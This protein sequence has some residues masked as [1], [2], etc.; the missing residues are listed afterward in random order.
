ME[1]NIT[2]VLFSLS[3]AMDS[4]ENSLLGVHTNHGKRVACLASAIGREAYGLKEQ[5][6]LE[7]SA[8]CVMHDNALTEYIAS[9]LNYVP[10]LTDAAKENFGRHCEIGERN[11]RLMPF[12]DSLD[13]VVLYHHEN[14]DGS[15]PF[16]L[17]EAQIPLYAQLVHFADIV[18]ATFFLGEMGEDKRKR[19]DAFL[20]E[21][22]SW[23]NPRIV[24]AFLKME[25][26]E[27]DMLSDRRI[28]ASLREI[29]PDRTMDLSAEQLESISRIFARI[30]DYKSHFTYTHSR[31][32]AEKAREMG[33]YYGQSESA[34]NILFAAGAF[35]DIGKMAV[36]TALL[37]KPGKLTD[38]EFEEIKKHAYVT[39]D[40]LHR[41]RGMGEI[42]FIASRH[43][44]KLDGSGYSFGIRGDS[45]THDER[46][47]CCVDIYQ[48]LTE[49]RPYRRG[50]KHEDAVRIMKEM[51]A[52]GVID[53]QITKDIDDRF[54]GGWKNADQQ[55]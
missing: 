29:I 17:K 11:F 47:M 54:H 51:A 37:D 45:L 36:P 9:E 5:E 35:H 4:V 25:R 31:D 7:L 26:P 19:I 15:G 6:L 48:A 41:I 42:T 52:S 20:K 33:H 27:A 28:D 13:N 12:D 46:L 32:I 49:D 30:V 18:D 8:C 34:C 53:A 3:F 16:G 2:D 14:S 43:H 10:Q 50:M 21:N 24:S 23:F 22:A 55:G 38:E 40:L 39:W 44:E 1:I